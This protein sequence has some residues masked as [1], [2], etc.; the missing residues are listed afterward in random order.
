MG[1][2]DELRR[3][4]D[5]QEEAGM[6]DGYYI[7]SGMPGLRWTVWGRLVGVLE[8]GD[9]PFMSCERSYTTRALEDELNR[10][11]LLR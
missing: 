2:K 1:R 8:Y 6:V 4:L 9:K 3:V 5:E 10:V 7:Q 11:N